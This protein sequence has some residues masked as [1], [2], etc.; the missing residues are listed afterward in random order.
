MEAT[1]V[2]RKVLSEADDHSIVISSIGFVQNIAHLLESEP[3]KYSSLNGYDLIMQKVKSI[4]WQGGHYPPINKFGWSSFNWD[5]GAR[6][7][8]ETEGC[9]GASEIAIHNMPPSVE[10][11]YSDIG[12]EIISGKNPQN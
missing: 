12:S 1:E 9:I 5:C 3:D 4:V 7:D 10:M 6:Y 11:I 2:Y 8:Y